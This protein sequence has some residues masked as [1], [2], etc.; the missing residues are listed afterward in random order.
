[1][2]LARARGGT[3]QARLADSRGA[4]DHYHLARAGADVSQ[5]SFERFELVVAIEQQSLH[6]PTVRRFP[7]RR[8]GVE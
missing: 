8:Q 5:L 3:Q 2:R 7:A 1:M 4:F 6:V